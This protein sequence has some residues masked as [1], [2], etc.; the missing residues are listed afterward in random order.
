M[1]ERRLDVVAQ[2]LEHRHQRHGGSAPGTPHSQPQK[3]IPTNTTTGFSVSR[4]P[5]IVG[6]TKY[7]SVKLSAK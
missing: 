6:V 7:P 2:D 4:R 1:G 3:T 5:T